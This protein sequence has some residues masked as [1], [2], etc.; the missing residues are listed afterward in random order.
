MIENSDAVPRS[1]W[2]TWPAYGQDCPV[3]RTLDTVRE[4]WT[5]LILRDLLRPGTRA[6]LQR[7]LV[8][9]WVIFDRP[10]QPGLGG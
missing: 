6:A 8:P 9:L 5:F 4:R 7:S 2:S 3:A 10:G 1:D